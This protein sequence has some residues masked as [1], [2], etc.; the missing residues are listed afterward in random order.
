[1]ISPGYI[2]VCTRSRKFVAYGITGAPLSQ[3]G[4]AHMRTTRTVARVAVLAALALGVGVVGASPIVA[5]TPA[6]SC[7]HVSGSATFTPGLTNTPTNQTVNAKGTETS[8][9]PSTTTGGSGALTAVIKVPL[10]SCGKLAT[11]NQTL[12]GTATTKW[13]NTKVSN[14]ALTFHT[15]TGSS[16]TIATITGKVTS[17]LFVNH[18]VT[19]QIKFTVQGTPNCTSMPVKNITFVNTKP[20]VI[21]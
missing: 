4:I 17:G 11:G 20:F 9:T 6:Q 7:A 10:G 15:G 12:H 2:R 1:M 5:A 8:C 3:E 14:Y 21:A 19:G 16:I 18:T 13:K